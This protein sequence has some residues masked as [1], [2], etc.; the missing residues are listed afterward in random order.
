[1]ISDTATVASGG[2]IVSDPESK[3]ERAP[4]RFAGLGCRSHA[5][6]HLFQLLIEP[7]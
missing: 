1:M 6:L 5:G 2:L 4:S 7:L 3:R